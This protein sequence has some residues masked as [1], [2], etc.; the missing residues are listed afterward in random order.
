[1]MRQGCDFFYCHSACWH[2]RFTN[3][4]VKTNCWH[5]SGTETWVLIWF[6]RDRIILIKPTFLC[7]LTGTHTH[8]HR[9]WSVFVSFWRRLALDSHNY[10]R[11]RRQ[12]EGRKISQAEAQPLSYNSPKGNH[13][14]TWVYASLSNKKGM[15]Y[16][17]ELCVRVCTTEGVS[18]I[19][20]QYIRPVT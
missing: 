18:E 11:S 17:R 6:M 8:T 14:W 4:V 20:I 9:V 2:V 19:V 7:H 5:Q 13:I 15:L 16:I 10:E 3:T 12:L 1:M